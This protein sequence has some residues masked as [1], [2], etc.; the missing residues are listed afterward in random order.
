MIPTFETS[1][2]KNNH[3]Q[4]PQPTLTHHNHQYQQANSP[5]NSH[6]ASS[7][8]HQQQM[9]AV[10]ATHNYAT[11]LSPFNN[12][13]DPLVTQQQQQQHDDKTT[14]HDTTNKYMLAVSSNVNTNK[15][16]LA[17][18]SNNKYMMTDPIS[19]NKGFLSS[20]TSPSLYNNNNHHIP[21]GGYKDHHQH[22]QPNHHHHHQPHPLFTNFQTTTF[23]QRFN[24]TQFGMSSPGY[25]PNTN[26]YNAGGTAAS[27][28]GLASFYDR[29][30]EMEAKLPL[31]YARV[32]L[33]HQTL[34]RRF[35]LCGNEMIITKMGRYEVFFFLFFS[36]YLLPY[37]S[38][39]F[40]TT[41]SF[42]FRQK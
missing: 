12:E 8:Q 39:F 27:G 14:T 15:G 7:S 19:N 29:M 18:T 16:F 22:S 25:F 42:S 24:P 9:S 1:T 38:A 21:F 5:N 10:T 34:W 28:M 30:Y 17:D 20:N 36:K 31:D 35:S 40:Y 2:T 32:W 11:S 23:H 33:D 26:P 41:Y 37:I 13:D 4:Q 3:H 6:I